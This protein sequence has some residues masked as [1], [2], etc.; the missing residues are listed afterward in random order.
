MQ[1]TTVH[2]ESKVRSLARD[3][4]E[5]CGSGLRLDFFQGLLA[6]VVEP[7][8]VALECVRAAWDFLRVYHG[9]MWS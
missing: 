7:L 4:T 3:R 1:M 9:S 5:S 6:L 8:L 2:S